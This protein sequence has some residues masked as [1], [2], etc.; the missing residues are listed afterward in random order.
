MT[1]HTKQAIQDVLLLIA[2]V[3]PT[4]GLLCFMAVVNYFYR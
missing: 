3:L 2:V 4:F 1:R